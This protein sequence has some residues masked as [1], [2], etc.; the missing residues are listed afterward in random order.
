MNS[1]LKTFATSVDHQYSST[2][3][4]FAIVSGIVFIISIIFFIRGIKN[5][6][7]YEMYSKTEVVINSLLLFFNIAVF[8]V[9]LIGNGI[10]TEDTAVLAGFC[11]TSIVLTAIWVVALF[12]SVTILAK[13]Y[14]YYNATDADSERPGFLQL[15]LDFIV[16]LILPF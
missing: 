6:L 5:V 11:V 13:R 14:S 3:N 15:I 10:N 4:T 16:C 9:S 1:L 12:T 8:A 2:L 7:K